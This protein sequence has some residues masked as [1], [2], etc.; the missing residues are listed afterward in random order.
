M[1]LTD[2]PKCYATPSAGMHPSHTLPLKLRAIAAAGFP[3]AEIAFPDLEA[4]AKA[5][6]GKEGREYGGVDE[7]GE[8]DVDG[9]V[10][11]AR[12]VRALCEELGVKVLAVHP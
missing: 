5:D 12:K 11:V 1:S 8:G 10:R 4:Y 2:I 9:L 7:K 6:L 3:F